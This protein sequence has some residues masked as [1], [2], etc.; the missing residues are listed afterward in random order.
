MPGGSANSTNRKDSPAA[1]SDFPS[2]RSSLQAEGVALD[3][4]PRRQGEVDLW[5]ALESHALVQADR[6]LHHVGG[7][8]CQCSSS[9][10]SGPACALLHKVLADAA[11]ASR[12]PHGQ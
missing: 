7:M 10:P 12:W 4:H 8:K 5:S 3:D 11:T 2:S 9:G 6:E 1:D